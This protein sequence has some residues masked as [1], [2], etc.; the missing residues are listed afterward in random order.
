MRSISGQQV[1]VFRMLAANT[2]QLD[3]TGPTLQ[4]AFIEVVPVGA[5]VPL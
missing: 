4:L 1:A 5:V 3:L 2:L